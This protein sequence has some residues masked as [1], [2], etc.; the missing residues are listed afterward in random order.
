MTQFDEQKEKKSKK[1]KKKKKGVTLFSNYNGSLPRR[2]PGAGHACIHILPHSGLL[3]TVSFERINASGLS[4]AQHGAMLLGERKEQRKGKGRVLL[5]R[6]LN[7]PIRVHSA[8]G[9]TNDE[10]CFNMQA[11][12]DRLQL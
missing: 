4:S 8:Y 6:V 10:W 1:K 5:G 12:R 2:Q 3:R 7:K 11:D 9:G